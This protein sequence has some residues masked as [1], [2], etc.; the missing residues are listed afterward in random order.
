MWSSHWITP[1]CD[2]ETKGGIGGFS[3]LNKGT[4]HWWTL[5]QHE[6]EAITLE[7]KTM[8]G[9]R[10]VLHLNSEMDK[11]RMQRDQAHV[12]NIIATFQNMVNPFDTSNLLW[13]RGMRQCCQRFNGSKTKRCNGSHRVL[14]KT[15]VITNNVQLMHILEEEI[16]PSATMRDIPDGAVWIWD[17]MALVQQLKPQPTFGLYADHVLRTLVNSAKANKTTEFHLVCDAYRNQSIKNAERSR[18]AEQRCQ[19]IKIYGDDQKTTKQWR[20]FLACG[21]KKTCWR[22]SSNTGAHLQRTL[23]GI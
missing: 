22:I 2:S 16:S 17:A 12:M 19:K 8:A 1:N 13:P 4:V 6:Q 9:Q 18:W 11:I 15:L 23:L 3:S 5:T 7:C 21:Q 10:P 20:K 14:W